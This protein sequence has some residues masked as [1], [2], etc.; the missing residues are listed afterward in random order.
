MK[1]SGRPAARRP[2]DY[3]YYMRIAIGYMRIAIGS[4]NR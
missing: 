3:L 4:V 1:L 2:C